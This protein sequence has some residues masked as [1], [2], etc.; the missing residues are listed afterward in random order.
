MLN[1]IEITAPPTFNQ[2]CLKCGA[3]GGVRMDAMSPEIIYCVRCNDEYNAEDVVAF[4]NSWLPFLGWA[5]EAR[6]IDA[7]PATPGL[8]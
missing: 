5:F 4:I 1:A 6:S 8:N 3:V 7:S 2:P